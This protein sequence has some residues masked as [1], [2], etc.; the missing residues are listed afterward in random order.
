MMV[1]LGFA[2][3]P[4]SVIDVKA[5]AYILHRYGIGRMRHID[6]AHLCLQDAVKSNRWKVRRVKSEDNLAD[7]GTK[8]L[9]N[10]KAWR[11]PRGTLPLKRT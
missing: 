7:I 2:V 6:V 5:T 8:A 1:D 3:R 10:K 11:H 4:V 9:S